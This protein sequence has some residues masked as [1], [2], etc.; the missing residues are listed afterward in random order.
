MVLPISTEDI[1][2]GTE[3]ALTWAMCLGGGGGG[4]ACVVGTILL[5]NQ[6][7]DVLT[8]GLQVFLRRDV[9]SWV[10]FPPPTVCDQLVKSAHAGCT[11]CS[12]LFP[13]QCCS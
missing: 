5:H 8:S 7:P 11:H 3:P 2:C 1:V 12:A 10:F 13:K 6:S 4:K 9:K